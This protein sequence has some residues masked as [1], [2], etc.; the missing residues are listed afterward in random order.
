MHLK[1]SSWCVSDSLLAQVSGHVAA[2]E[3]FEVIKPFGESFGGL[4]VRSAAVGQSVGAPALQRLQTAQITLLR[5]RQHVCEVGIA[6]RGTYAH[7]RTQT[8]TEELRMKT[9]D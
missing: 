3:A 5:V 4:A 9:D 6:A 2:L 7:E 8:T 1:K